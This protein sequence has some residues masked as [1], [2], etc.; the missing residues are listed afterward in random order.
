[1]IAHAQRGQ[2][3]VEF[4]LTSAVALLLILGVLEMGR[5]FFAYDFVSQAARI[6][7]R[8]AIVNSTPCSATQDTSPCEQAIANY[9]KA[10]VPGIDPA[11]LSLL[12]TWQGAP[13]CAGTAQAGCTVA[14]E[15]DY[16]FNFV[17]LPLPGPTLRSSSQMT[18]SQ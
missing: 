3:L 10:N 4:A 5:A 7:T 17:A 12:F 2:A 16:A 6:G 9:V 1:M 13:A 8:Y 15:V 18:I 11:K 14:I